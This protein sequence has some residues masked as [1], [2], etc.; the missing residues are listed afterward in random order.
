[1]AFINANKS[2]S[3][4]GYKKK[5]DSNAEEVLL[6]IV[7]VS[8]YTYPFKSMVRELASNALDSIREKNMALNIIAGKEK[9]SD[10]YLEIDGNLYEDSKF[11]IEYYNPFYLDKK[12]LVEI[13]YVNRSSDLRDLFVI[14]DS[15]VGLGGKRLEKFFTPG[16]SSK[17][18]NVR[19]LGSY[20]LGSKS[21]L[22]TG[23]DFYTMTSVYNGMEFCFDVYKDKVDSVYGKYNEDGTVND[24]LLFNEVDMKGEPMKV[25]YKKT[26]LPNGVRIETEVKKHNKNQVIEAI[27]SQLMYFKENIVAYEVNNDTKSEIKFKANILYEDDNLLLS[28]STYYARPHFVMKSVN[29]GLIDFKE[30]D[31]DLKV[32]N[33]GIKVDMSEVD[34]HP[35]RESIT[36]TAKTRETVL[37]KYATIATGVSKMLDKKLQTDD[38]LE[39]VR[40]VN[41]IKYGSLSTSTKED[42]ILATLANL[43]DKETIDSKFTNKKGDVIEHKGHILDMIGKNFNVQQVSLVKNWNNSKIERKENLSVFILNQPIVLQFCKATPANTAYILQEKFNNYCSISLKSYDED[44]EALFLDYIEGKDNFSKLDAI[45]DTKIKEESTRKHIKKEVKKSIIFLDSILESKH[46]PLLYHKIVVPEGYVGIKSEEDTIQPVEEDLEQIKKE[47]YERYKKILAKRKENESF[48]VKTFN[49][50]YS[51]YQ[52]SAPLI[53]NTYEVKKS[54]LSKIN[55]IVYG[56]T[57]DR[58]QLEKFCKTVRYLHGFSGSTENIVATEDLYVVM[59]AKENVNNLPDFAVTTSEYGVLYDNEN[60]LT[61]FNYLITFFENYLIKSVIEN[62][63]IDDT[64]LRQLYP[65]LYKMLSK[66]S[67]K[68]VNYDI[69][70]FDRFPGLQIVKNAFLAQL[71]IFNTDSQDEVEIDDIMTSFLDIDIVDSCNGLNIISKEFYNNYLLLKDFISVFGKVL[72]NFNVSGNKYLYDMLETYITANKHKLLLE[73]TGLN[74]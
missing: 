25:Y 42:Q 16:W 57:V 7:Q 74:A 13:Q 37:N 4:T 45:L 52:E 39:W 61:T 34:V 67:Y 20:G 65:L 59:I 28:D 15:G 17:R 46:K 64:I 56:T 14:F 60:K 12:D 26:G 72:H 2:E 43:I 35:S 27:K 5:L 9:V 58:E 66:K 1:M 18:L 44:I 23:V 69:N 10:Y 36:Y 3:K 71:R 32:G 19:A 21:P 48:I 70:V 31:L 63:Y 29:Y 50:K 55:N 54:E 40:G 41:N 49:D 8:L 22:A 11:D 47:N 30:L 33:I 62:L 73:H 6:N 68:N 24:Y 53:T 38:F 51:Y